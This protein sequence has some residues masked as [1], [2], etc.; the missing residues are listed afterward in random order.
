MN[1]N[2]IN[3][4]FIHRIAVLFLVIVFCHVQ[5]FSQC[6]TPVVGCPGTNLSN[7][8]MNSS[9]NF[10]TVEY[11]N[12]ISSFHSTIVR[13]RDGSFLIWGEDMANNGTSNVLN[14]RTINITN[15][16]ALTGVPLK[17]GL[18]SSSINDVQGILLTTTGLFAWSTEGRVLDGSITTST[19]FQKLTIGGNANGLPTGVTPADVKM[20]YVGNRMIAITTCSGSV[21]VISQIANT[22]GNGAA[23]NSTTWYQVTT[24]LAGNPALTGIVACRGSGN[25]LFALKSDRTLWVWG[26]N[27]YLANGTAAATRNRA[28]Q[29]NSPTGTAKKMIGVSY[30]G[31]AHSYYVID[32]LSRLYALGRNAFRQLGDWTTTER[33][34][35]VQPRYTSAAGP[36][37]NNIR[38]ISTNETDNSGAE[39]PS[40]NILTR[41]ST[42]YCFGTDSRNMMGRAGSGSSN[43]PAIPNNIT[44]A[45]KILFV[46]T[47]GHTSM[48]VKRCTLTFGYVGHR[49]NGSMGNGSG[50]D[51]QETVYTFAT[52]NVQ[53]CGSE[54]SPNIVISTPSIFGGINGNQCANAKVVLSASPPG[55]SLSIVSGP[56]T[57][58]GDTLKFTGVGSVVVKYR[59]STYC[60][61]TDSFVQ[62]YVTEACPD[63]T[64]GDGVPNY[65]DLDNDNDG[66]LDTLECP[67][68]KRVNNGTFTGSTAGWTL[69]SGWTLNCNR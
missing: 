69:G 17:A 36:V 45:D 41:D 40:V 1:K 23:G 10:T 2:I 16:P 14:P 20:L 60:G 52:A 51:L 22:R 68:V 37:M 27:T 48:I 11:D 54:T 61:F 43:N 26:S 31:T 44:A 49:V 19:T 67:L 30:D 24:N 3:S 53:V 9:N 5:I 50:A 21:W 25:S 56:G 47:G 57:L 59:V 46:K 33:T 63:S 39:S 55:G 13:S 35:W 6:S 12:Y 18:G 65:V 58:A 38:W 62:T 4:L 34:T 32:T 64:D 66:I 15:Y 7:S 42:L 29:M 8:G 28:T